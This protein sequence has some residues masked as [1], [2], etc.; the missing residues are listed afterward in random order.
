MFIYW[1]VKTFQVN[2][3]KYCFTS[4]KNLKRFKIQIENQLINLV[5][6]KLNADI[7]RQYFSIKYN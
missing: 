7:L 3:I 2:Q 5:G 6:I 4:N 1:L